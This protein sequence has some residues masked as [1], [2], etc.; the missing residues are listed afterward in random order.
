MIEALGLPVTTVTKVLSGA[1]PNVVDV[2]RDG[3]VQCW[4]SN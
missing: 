3:T 2:I 1:H 4:G